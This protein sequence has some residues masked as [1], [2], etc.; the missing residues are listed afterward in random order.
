MGVLTRLT[1]LGNMIQ[2]DL[3]SVGLVGEMQVASATNGVQMVKVRDWVIFFPTA[4][5]QI[6]RRT[7]VKHAKQTKQNARNDQNHEQTIIKYFATH[8]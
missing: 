7:I 3:T 4:C 6:V 1:R 5:Q 8:V 2:Q